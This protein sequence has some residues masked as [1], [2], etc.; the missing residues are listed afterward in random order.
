MSVYADSDSQVPGQVALHAQG[1]YNTVTGNIDR[2]QVTNGA[3]NAYV[4]NMVNQGTQIVAANLLLLASYTLGPFDVSKF[5]TILVKWKP[6]TITGTSVALA[7]IGTDEMGI[8]RTIDT[9]TENGGAAA[10]QI[11]YLGGGAGTDV[12]TGSPRRFH[13]QFDRLLSLTFTETALTAIAGTIS[14]TGY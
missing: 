6:T 5:H 8:T 4:A 14:V 3:G 10:D 12:T 1:G 9:V 13:D 11:W 2:I 7:L